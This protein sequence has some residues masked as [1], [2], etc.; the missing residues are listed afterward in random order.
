L[1]G[2]GVGTGIPNIAGQRPVYLHLE[3]RAYQSGARGS[4]AMMNAVKFLSDDALFQVAA[5]YSSQEPAAGA[6]GE[7]VAA[8]DPLQAG[9]A[10]SAGCAGCHGVGFDPKYL[11]SAMKAY[12]ST[13]RKN[14][15]MRTMLSAMTETDMNNIALYYALQK[16][17][18]ARPTAGSDQ[19]KSA[20]AP[21]AGCHGEQGV[22]S[23]PTTPS[24]AGQDSQYLVAALQAYKAATRSDETMKGITASLDEKTMKN[25]A[26][27]F[28][29]QRPQAPKDVRKP[30]TTDEWA[31]R[32]DRCHGIN[33][34]S[35]D[36]RLPALA[37]QREEYLQGALHA[38]QKGERKSVAMAAMS[39]VLSDSD[40]ESLANHYAHQKARA[41]VYVIQGK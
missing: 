25:I 10:A 41:Y 9:K 7:P 8:K 35:T 12:K 40:I 21:C 39:E 22:S 5:Y 38:Y 20:V 23:N 2:V 24:L 16:P 36:P 17:G 6:P 31:Q 28:S 15:M 30:L 3:L 26:A 37:S 19:G 11:V 18:S 32:C 14:D 27:Y 33:G 4:T 34:N 29:S 13:Q 1:N